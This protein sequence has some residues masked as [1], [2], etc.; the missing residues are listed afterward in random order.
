MPA[1][2]DPDGYT[3]KVGKIVGT[4]LGFQDHGIFT[5]ELQINYGDYGQTIGGWSLQREGG[6]WIIG[7]LK[8]CGVNSWEKLPGRIVHVLLDKNDIGVGIEPLP[9]EPGTRFV[10]K[11]VFAPKE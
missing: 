11:D 4:M 3:K 7:V 1:A 6:W 10:F 2:E 5:G 8:A 9:M